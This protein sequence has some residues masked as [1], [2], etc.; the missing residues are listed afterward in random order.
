MSGCKFAKTSNTR[1]TKTAFKGSSKVLTST[2]Q[3]ASQY[4]AELY[5]HSNSKLSEKNKHVN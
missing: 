5:H 1:N 2:M 4:K 3:A